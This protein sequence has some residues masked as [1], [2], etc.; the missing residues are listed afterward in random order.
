LEYKV[1]FEEIYMEKAEWISDRSAVVSSATDGEYVYF[2]SP[3]Y[4]LQMLGAGKGKVKGKIYASKG[5]IE[6]KGKLQLLY[7]RKKLYCYTDSKLFKVD[8]TTLALK[9]SKKMSRLGISPPTKLSG[10]GN[11]IV[12]YYETLKEEAK[13]AKKLKFK[14]MSPYTTWQPKVNLCESL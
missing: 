1:P 11:Q 6:A 14:L 3:T 10:S 9:E 2:Y 5:T 12:T 7:L 13:K 4:G 8:P